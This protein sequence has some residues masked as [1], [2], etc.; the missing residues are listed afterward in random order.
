[1]VSI[2]SAPVLAAEG[3]GSDWWATAYPIIPHPGELI[4]GLIAIAVLYFVVAK[5]VVPRLEAMFAERAE[6]I[7]GGIRKAESAQAEAAQA[8]EQYRSE[9]ADARAE[10][11]RIIQ[12]ASE[13]AA[14]VAA[15]IRRR[16][17]EEA[18]RITAAA[19]QQIQAERQQ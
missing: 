7:E 18:E 13:E 15:E 17:S 6:A 19:S 9:R 14:A 8:L 11:A 16:A 12:Q 10:R 4:F 1:M 5:F 3:G 2:S